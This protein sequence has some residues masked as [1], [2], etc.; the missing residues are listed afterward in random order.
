[1]SKPKE[2]LKSRQVKFTAYETV[3]Y[4]RTV[5]IEGIDLEVLE[6]A[7]KDGDERQVNTLLED[8]VDRGDIYD[9][10]D[11]EV[12]DIEILKPTRKAKP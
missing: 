2:K 6:S 5:T 8:Y 3:R 11:F 9:A 4:S 7:L 1:M 12:D 10:D